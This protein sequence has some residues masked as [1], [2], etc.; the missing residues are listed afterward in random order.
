MGSR[1]RE[2]Q[3]SQVEETWGIELISHTLYDRVSTHIDSCGQT[4]TLEWHHPRG[5]RFQ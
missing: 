3:G 4:T 2:G 1:V 5:L